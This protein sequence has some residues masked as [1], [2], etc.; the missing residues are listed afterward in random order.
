MLVIVALAAI[1][2]GFAYAVKVETVLAR[3]AADDYEFDWLGRS[4]LELA[5]FAVGQQMSITTEPYD[6]LNQFWSGGQYV[7]NE[8]FQDVSLTDVE[9]GSGRLSVKIVDQERRFNINI[10]DEAVLNQGFALVGVD[11]VESATAV[12]S[13]L[14]WIDPDD[15][16]RIN[17]TESEHYLSLSPPYRA[18]NGPL[19][20][21]SELLLVQGVTPAMF[22]GTSPVIDDSRAAPLRL[23]SRGQRD[24][25]VYTNAL[26]NLFTTTSARL[27]NINTAAA[28]VFQLIPGLDPGIAAAI[29]MYR[30]GPDGQEGTEDDQPFRSVR[31]LINIPG[32]DPNSLTAAAR[33]FGVRSATYEVTVR[34]EINGRVREMVGLIMRNNSARDVRILL[35]YWK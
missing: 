32:M 20:D 7:T 22:D 24:I 31:D 14:D 35:A 6:S 26:K 1:A 3:N 23:R 10:A 9:L 12:S 8:V 34:V 33:I 18:K 28:E 27:I 29:L 13:I 4:G 15:E 21:L 2:G 25:P 30:A 17:G 16:I 5:R 19:D 11:P